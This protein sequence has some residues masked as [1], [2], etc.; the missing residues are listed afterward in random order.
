MWHRGS[1]GWTW[2]CNDFYKYF[3]EK[4][5]CAS[6]WGNEWIFGGVWAINRMPF[7]LTGLPWSCW[8]IKLYKNVQNTAFCTVL[9]TTQVENCYG[10]GQVN[11]TYNVSQAA[12]VEVNSFLLGTLFWQFEKRKLPRW[13]YSRKVLTGLLCKMYLRHWCV[14]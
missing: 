2:F 7:K 8:I 4:L 9:D 6:G 11:R 13:G 10:T 12:A 1:R 5:R 14:N 3:A